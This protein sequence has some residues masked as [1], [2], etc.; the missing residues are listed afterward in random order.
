VRDSGDDGSV[1][2]AGDDGLVGDPDNISYC[3]SVCLGNVS[4]SS[5]S[6]E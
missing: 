2:D 6:A 5:E 1:R 3:V 4:G